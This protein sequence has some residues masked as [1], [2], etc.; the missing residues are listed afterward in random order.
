MQNSS[1]LVGRD[2]EI[3]E[4]A[5]V[6]GNTGPAARVLLLTGAIGSGKTAVA[7]AACRMAAN[8]GVSVVRLDWETAQSASS[9]AVLADAVCDALVQIRD[10]WLP[11][12][13]AAVR[14]VQ[15]RSAG[16]GSAVPLMLSTLGEALADA[17]LHVPF[18]LLVDDTD[19]MH[20]QTAY[21]LGLL[22]RAFRP[23]GVPV[24]LVGRPGI[25]GSRTRADLSAVADRSLGLAPLPV[26]QVHALIKKRLRRPVDPALVAAVCRALGPLAGNPEA[27]LCILTA[28]KDRG[29]L[30]EID[31]WMC[32]VEPEDRLCF[33]ADWGQL[34]RLG[35]ADGQ[36][37]ADAMELAPVMARI[38]GNAE[39]RLDDVDALVPGPGAVAV[40]RTLDRLIR[41]RVLTVDSDERVAFAVPAIAATLH[42]LPTRTDVR[43]IHLRIVTAITGRLEAQVAG[44]LYPRLVEHVAAAGPALDDS[45]AVPLLLAV[46]RRDLRGQRDR[47]T[48]AYLSVV[49]R[50]V[51]H[52]CLRDAGVFPGAGAFPEAAVFQEAAEV[53]L[54]IANHEGVLAF[55][56]PLLASSGAAGIAADGTVA[57][58]GLRH[59]DFAFRAEAFAALHEHRAPHNEGTDPQ[60][61]AVLT[62]LPGAAAVAALG[63]RYGIGPEPATG[64]DPVPATPLHPHPHDSRADTALPTDSGLLPRPSEVRLLA[65]ASGGGA[66]FERALY[67]VRSTGLPRAGG[68]TAVVTAAAA[69]RLRTAAA[70]G[71]LAGAFDAVLADR[72]V[73]PGQSIAGLY[74]DMVRE[75]LAGDWSDALSTAIRIE[76]RGRSHGAVDAGLPARALAA[77][78]HCYRGDLKRAA[79]WMRLIPAS[80]SHPLVDRAR[81]TLRH[82]S[83]E[84]QSAWDTAWQDVRHAWRTGLLMGLE[85]LLLRIISLGLMRDRR[86]LALRALGEIETLYEETG[87]ALSRETLL[88]GHGAVHHDPQS[89]LDGHLLVRQRGDHLL[90]VYTSHCLAVLEDDPV[91]RIAEATRAAEKL[92]AD[93]VWQF[94]AKSARQYGMPVPRR[95]A[96]REGAGG[97]DPRLVEMV[98]EGATNRQIATR[99]VCSEKTVE[100]RLTRLFQQTGCRSRVELAAVWLKGDLAHLGLAPDA[101]QHR[102]PDGLDGRATA[103]QS[104]RRRSVQQPE[105]RS[106]HGHRHAA[107]ELKSQTDGPTDRTIS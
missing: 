93:R 47:V 68:P 24:V 69:D 80:V 31:G 17:A 75:Y 58:A 44:R 57:E 51:H 16:Q 7:N 13:I 95:R 25:P 42:S 65:A 3:R 77:E 1:S 97:L 107:E 101:V 45:V 84:G 59:L 96:V 35:W 89:A 40:A 37:D 66:E 28:L 11:L 81:L 22:L 34:G 48:R 62:R 4:V 79:K 46:A 78:I 30:S 5:Q 87:S 26:S 27:V 8:A 83:G 99:L 53:N 94:L 18:A 6:L 41:D 56:E 52:S 50:S 71:D 49:G 102:R 64:P 92:A 106:A 105:D 19:R 15:S 12:R 43:S 29:S 86:D 88:I 73:G 67:E 90:L 39:F 91:P 61:R 10:G 32:L 63:R 70:F 38:V 54:R 76:V 23:A 33:P 21:E 9:T 98:S 104:P 82:W 60:Y 72:Y 55:S 74:R 103:D 85:R 14:R 36:P 2:N 20:P 100:Q